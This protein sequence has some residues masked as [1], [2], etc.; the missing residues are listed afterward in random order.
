MYTY[1]CKRI[2]NIYTKIYMYIKEPKLIRKLWVANFGVFLLT[3][4]KH[5]YHRSSFLMVSGD[6]LQMEHWLEMS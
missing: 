2:Y 6:I 4:F 1:T 3:H 5:L